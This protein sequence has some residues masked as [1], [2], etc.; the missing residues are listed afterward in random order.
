[1]QGGSPESLHHRFPATAFGVRQ[2]FNP[3]SRRKSVHSSDRSDQGEFA[4]MKARNLLKK[5]VLGNKLPKRP[6]LAFDI[7]IC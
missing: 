2:E 6:P 4:G 1:M 5:K 3:P 7:A